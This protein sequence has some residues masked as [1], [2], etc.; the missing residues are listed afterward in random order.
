MDQ[1]EQSVFSLATFSGDD[2]G[3][4]SFQFFFANLIPDLAHFSP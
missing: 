2:Q 1:E 3:D 4:L